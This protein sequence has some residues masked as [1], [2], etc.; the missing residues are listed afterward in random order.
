M[1]VA[2]LLVTLLAMSAVVQGQTTTP[3]INIQP[4]APPGI[5]T[6]VQRLI[7]WLYWGAWVAVF[8]AGIYG[9][10]NIAMGDAEKGKKYVAGAIIGA[11]V[12]AALTV[13]IPALTGG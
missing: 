13:I 6:M 12:L 3:P 8:G 9:G 4:E 1:L 5:G 7:N 10:F 11:I 2:G